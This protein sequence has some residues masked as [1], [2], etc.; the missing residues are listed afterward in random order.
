[1]KQQTQEQQRQ[2]IKKKI[3]DHVVQIDAHPDY[4]RVSSMNQLTENSIM[5]SS[6]RD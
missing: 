3:F 4:G 2:E 6:P 5:G 1:V